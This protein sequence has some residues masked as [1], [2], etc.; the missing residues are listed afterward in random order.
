MVIDD[1]MIDQ[2][3]NRRVIERSGRVEHCLYFSGGED[4]LLYLRRTE[5]PRVDAILLDVN[6]P[7]MTGFE[8]LD[9]ATTEFGEGFTRVAVVMLTT[10]MSEADQHRA[11]R[12]SVVKDYICKP[13]DEGH[14]HKID[15][16]LSGISDRAVDAAVQAVRGDSGTGIS[17]A[18]S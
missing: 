16:M 6:M 3:L 14:L 1:N 13:L 15:A 5:R 10:S 7:R 8:F 17:D 2:K 4:A 12:Y 9:A 11:G 18:A